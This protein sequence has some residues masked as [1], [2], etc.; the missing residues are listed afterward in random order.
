MSEGQGEGSVAQV[1]KD[2]YSTAVARC[3]QDLEAKKTQVSLPTSQAPRD[4]ISI[5][6]PTLHSGAAGCWLRLRLSSPG[7]EP[8]TWA[9]SSPLSCQ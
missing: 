5:P 1:G 7:E 8:G 2:V 9:L 6:R 4:P 3:S